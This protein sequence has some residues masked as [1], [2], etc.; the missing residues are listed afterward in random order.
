[1]EFLVFW[2]QLAVHGRG[3]Q[4]PAMCWILHYKPE[5]LT[6]ITPKKDAC[7]CSDAKFSAQHPA[8]QPNVS[9]QHLQQYYV[10]IYMYINRDYLEAPRQLTSERQTVQTSPGKRVWNR[11]D[12][13]ARLS[14]HRVVEHVVCWLRPGVGFG[15]T[16]AAYVQH[17]GQLQAQA[18][19][20]IQQVFFGMKYLNKQLTTT[21][22]GGKGRP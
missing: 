4:G 22:R 5:Q 3:G 10:L 8:P 21:A 9:L 2:P 17:A 7:S 20:K 1:M 14:C 6:Q 16:I 11:S 15:F 18:A 19:G 12:I 13:L